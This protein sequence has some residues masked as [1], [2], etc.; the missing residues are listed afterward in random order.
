MTA[1][2]NK[3]LIALLAAGVIAAASVGTAAARVQIQPGAASVIDLSAKEDKDKKKNKGQQ[4]QKKNPGS[5][6][7][8]AL[9]APSQK[10]FGG[11]KSGGQKQKSG[12]QQQKQFGG[13]KSGGQKQK[14]SSQGGKSQQ[15]L[16]G[17]KSGGQKQKFG[18]QPPQQL[19]GSKGGKKQGGPGKLGQNKNV[20]VYKPKGGKNY[21]TVTA[22]KLHGLPPGSSKAYVH[23]QNYS[24]WRGPNGYRYRY[25]NR[26]RTFVPLSALAVLL[27]GPRHYYPYAYISAPEYY[28][29][30]RTED[31]CLLNW[32]EV[33]TLEG[34]LIGH[35][36]AY[37]PWQEY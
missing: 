15:Q 22:K 18:G 29:I 13:S 27:V 37:C 33:E 17:S 21:N 26:W 28:C 8:G 6:N 35:C 9:G 36:V 25:H 14:S 23:G 7:K 2:T 30:G 32:E 24:A 5:Q 12:A 34:D 20:K 11:S 19:G 10:K 4:Q 16:G 1:M 31:G 3:T